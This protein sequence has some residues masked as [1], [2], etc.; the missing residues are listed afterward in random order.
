MGRISSVGYVGDVGS[1][2]GRQRRHGKDNRC[3]IHRGREG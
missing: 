2:L 1:A 3:W